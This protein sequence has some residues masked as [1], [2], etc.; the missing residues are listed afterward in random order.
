M[1]KHLHHASGL[2][3]WYVPYL[4]LRKKFRKLKFKPNQKQVI[5][6]VVEIRQALLEEKNLNLSVTIIPSKQKVDAVLLKKVITCIGF[7]SRE[8]N[9]CASAGHWL[10]VE[11]ILIQ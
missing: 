3:D 2:G 4:Q 6:T 10:Q 1:L 9:L 5:L 8:I 7:E 11:R